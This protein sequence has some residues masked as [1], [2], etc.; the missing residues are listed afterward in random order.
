MS[1][2]YGAI[3]RLLLPKG[4]GD[5]VKELMVPRNE[6]TPFVFTLKKKYDYERKV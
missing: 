2:Q 4:N 3:S 1:V 6:I 5:G